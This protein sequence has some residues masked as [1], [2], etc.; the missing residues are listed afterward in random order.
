MGRMKLGNYP[1]A[2]KESDLAENAYFKFLSISEYLTMTL[3]LK[4]YHSLNM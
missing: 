2:V 4:T 1:K 3:T